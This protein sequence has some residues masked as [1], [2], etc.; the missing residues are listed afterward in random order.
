M[1]RGRRPDQP[2][3]RPSTVAP[4][5][6]CIISWMEQRQLVIGGLFVGI[7]SVIVAVTFGLFDVWS[8]ISNKSP[9]QSVRV[10]S[11]L[12]PTPT[13][14]LV[15]TAT[16][17]DFDPSSR[18]FEQMFEGAKAIRSSTGRGNALRTVAEHSVKKGSYDNA[19]KAARA[20]P[21]STKRS[22]ALNFVAICAAKDK[23]FGSAIEAAKS[24]PS[25]RVQSESMNEVLRIQTMEQ[26][27]QPIRSTLGCN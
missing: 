2:P 14:I 8:Y 26:Q 22:E 17:S 7:L 25:S 18:T 23:Q 12:A 10:Y 9:D 5:Q 20:I 4:F 27:G 16:P 3:D 15:P 13:S 11:P 24:I 1:P 21:S 6:S 19:I